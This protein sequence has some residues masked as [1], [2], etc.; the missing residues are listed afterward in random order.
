MGS[1]MGKCSYNDDIH[2][3]RKR[4]TEVRE[5]FSKKYSE[6]WRGSS[7]KKTADPFVIERNNYSF[8]TSAIYSSPLRED[9]GLSQFKS[10]FAKPE[11]SATSQTLKFTSGFDK[12]AQ[13]AN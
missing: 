13:R 2:C 9:R 4:N 5:H 3:R 7:V 1:S 6:Y 11:K 10:S 12:A 8:S